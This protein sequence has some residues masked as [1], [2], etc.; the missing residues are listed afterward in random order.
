MTQLFV[1][2]SRRDDALAG[3]LRSALGNL[4]MKV[5]DY[6]EI[7]PGDDWRHAIQKAIKGSDAYLLIASPEA[8]ASSW[9]SY[10]TGMA[11]AL[12]KRVLVLLRN[13][14]SVTE[15]P[16]ELAANQVINFDPQRP[17]DAAHDVAAHLAA[18][19]ASGSIGN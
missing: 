11:E 8:T 13:G 9:T 3:R 4:G 15:L 12:G 18:D 17:E 5:F 14:H 2:Y 16:E 19:A 7:R 6:S 1:S 10:E